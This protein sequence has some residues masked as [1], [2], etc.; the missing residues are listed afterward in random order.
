MPD[1]PF[2]RRKKIVEYLWEHDYADVASLSHLCDVSEM[3]IR[4]DL[5]KLEKDGDVVRVYGGAKIKINSPYEATVEERLNTNRQEKMLIAE[6]AA[7][8]IN[9]G[10]VIVFDASTSALEVSK[11]IKDRQRLTVIT[12]NI[13]IAIELSG[14]ANITTILLGGTLRG[15]SLSLVGA[16]IKKGLEGIFIDKA[17]I[18][19]RALN[20][21]EGLTDITIEE[22]EAKQALIEKAK[23]VYVLVDHTKVDKL[24]FFQVC[25]KKEIH[26][27]ITD[28]LNELTDEQKQCLENYREYGVE[29]ISCC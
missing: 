9:D 13:S 29:V 6:K 20:F 3:T 21:E 24:S 4:R 8:L 26:T 18:S 16:S 25:D 2:V 19:S 7:E 15:S 28:G 14:A 1:I 23:R 22:G 10:D 17:F 12:N 27:I 11:L 5:E